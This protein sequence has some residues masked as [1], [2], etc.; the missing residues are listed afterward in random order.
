MRPTLRQIEY[1]VTVAELCSFRKAADKLAVTQPSLSKQIQTLEA[2]LGV[3]LFERSSRQV[4]LSQ[5]GQALLEDARALLNQAYGFKAKT[6]E[7]RTRQ[8]YHLNA[9]VLPSIGAYFMP[10]FTQRLRSVFPDLQISFIEG[11]SQELLGKLAQGEVDFVIASRGPQADFCTK[12]LFEET[13]WICSTP[14]DDLMQPVEPAPLEALKGRRLVTLSPDFHLSEI[15]AEL[16]EKAGA[17]LST[18]YRGSSLD[19]IRQIAA[20][21]SA[22]AVLPSL[23]ALG[24]AIRD[25]AFRVRRLAHPDAIHPVLL[26]WRRTVRDQAFYERLAVEIIAEKMAIREERAPHLRV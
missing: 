23:Y 17:E 9:G 22:V 11:S 7:L 19:A 26:Y 4:T 3:S 25:P 8:A 20:R 6:K 21:S 16:A 24:E 13:L 18:E 14:E 2:E 5:P 10:R 15:V 1:F 12:S